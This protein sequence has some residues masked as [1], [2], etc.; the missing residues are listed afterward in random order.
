MMPACVIAAAGILPK[1]WT[2]CS[3]PEA[4]PMDGETATPTMKAPTA[5]D[6]TGASRRLDVRRACMFLPCI[7]ILLA[8][9]A[10]FGGILF[11]REI[12]VVRYG[13]EC[14]GRMREVLAAALVAADRLADAEVVGR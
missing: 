2:G 6:A 10:D 14:L 3:L 13:P 7:P 5:T 4:E 8:V 1:D 9:V 11:A 12:A